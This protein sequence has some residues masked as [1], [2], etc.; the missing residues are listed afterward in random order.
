VCRLGIQGNRV[1]P[2]ATAGFDQ[3][4]AEQQTKGHPQAP[5]AGLISPMDMPRSMRVAPGRAVIMVMIRAVG[6]A[7]LMSVGMLIHKRLSYRNEHFPR[8]PPALGAMQRDLHLGLV[9]G[10]WRVGGAYLRISKLLPWSD[11]FWLS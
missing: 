4:E 9:A 10:A 5:L 11:A 3:R 6:V 7:M 2:Q 8:Y 1:G